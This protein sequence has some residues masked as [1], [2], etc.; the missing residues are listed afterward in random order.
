[1][2]D[3]LFATSKANICQ[4]VKAG[5]LSEEDYAEFVLIL[6]KQIAQLLVICSIPS[7][8]AL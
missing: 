7:S 6:Q 3:A 8:N 4:L 2:V 5:Y 1:M